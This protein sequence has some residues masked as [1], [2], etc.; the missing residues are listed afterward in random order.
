L[1]TYTRERPPRCES[2]WL[3]VAYGALGVPAPLVSLPPLVGGATKTPKVLVRM[4]GSAV[5]EG[6]SLSGR[7]SP[8]HAW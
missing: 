7:Q 4:H 3:T 2:A 6:T 1:H 8:E 5:F